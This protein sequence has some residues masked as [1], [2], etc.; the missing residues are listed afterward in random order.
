MEIKYEIPRLEIETIV[1]GVI[2]VKQSKENIQRN[3][4][5][6]LSRHIRHRRRRII[7]NFSGLVE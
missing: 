4:K 1:D 6:L 3:T 7:K 2:T 5:R